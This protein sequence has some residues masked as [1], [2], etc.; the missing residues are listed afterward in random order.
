MWL[1]FL[2]TSL[3]LLLFGFLL[4]RSA[5]NLYQDRKINVIVIT[6]ESL[7]NDLVTRKNC[8][9]LLKKAENSISFAGHRAISGWTGANMVSLLTGLS[10]FQSGVHTRGQSVDPDLVLPLEQLTEHGYTVEGLQS[11][12]A[13]D[14]YRNLGLSLNTG[15]SNLKYYLAQKKNDKQPFFFWH[16]YTHTHLPYKASKKFRHNWKKEVDNSDNRLTAR[17]QTVVTKSALHHDQY[18]F[19][20]SDAAIIHRIQG[21]AVKEFD[22]W[23]ESF[24]T[25]FRKSGLHR[26]SILI[27]TA[28]H[29][30]EHGERGSVGHASTTLQGHLHEE[31]VRIPLF[32]WLPEMI[33]HDAGSIAQHNSS[34]IDLMPTLFGL[35]DIQPEI[36]FSGTNLLKQG[37]TASTWM[38]MTSGGGF[39]EPD[40]TNIRYFEYGLIDRDL[41]LL[42]RIDREGSIIPRLYDLSKDPLENNNLVKT[43]AT[44]TKRLME[45]LTEALDKMVVR[46]VSHQSKPR[47]IKGKSGPRWIRPLKDGLY[48]YTNLAGKF[49]LEWTGS[50]NKQYIIQ[51]RAGVG[52]TAITGEITSDGPIKDFGTIEQ[53]FWETWIIP[54]SPFR[55]RVR[56]VEKG[57]WSKWLK[58]E[59]VQ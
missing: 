26:N 12:M 4:Y 45:R 30:D 41:K 18:R 57:N 48:S 36:P 38:A 29:G 50:H 47:E 5:D 7:R 17:L 34:H 27:V 6:V 20:K 32:I 58:L 40:H 24:W 52:K 23:F 56:N 28:D 39:A 37:Y 44:E 59:A 2:S 21:G 9:V 42:V 35:L 19:K 11:F 1:R 14:I 54:N 10:P 16:H 46:P 22:H 13:M 43:L 51:Y 53:K 49:Q 3:A 55:L 15:G 8:P 33:K 25:F 31:I